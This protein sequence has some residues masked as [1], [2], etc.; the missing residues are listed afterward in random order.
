MSCKD[1]LFGEHSEYQRNNVLLV[2]ESFWLHFS[3][4]NT[5]EAP[6]GLV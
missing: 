5:L 1:N 2:G 6:K 3:I 4:Y